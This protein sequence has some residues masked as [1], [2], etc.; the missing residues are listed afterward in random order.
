MSDNPTK[1]SM[2]PAMPANTAP[3]GAVHAGVVS[4]ADTAAD[5]TPAD[6]GPAGVVDL[7][8]QEGLP[9]GAVFLVSELGLA[10]PMC[11]PPGMWGLVVLAV[12]S[13]TADGAP[14]PVRLPMGT[15]A[16]RRPRGR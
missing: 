7:A 3:D 9:A 11:T 4:G 6:P 8:V 2:P 5:A 12:N 14:R 10:P 1:P 16:A 15:R 13:R